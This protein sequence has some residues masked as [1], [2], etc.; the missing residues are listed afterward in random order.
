MTQDVM[1][2]DKDSGYVST[3]DKAMTEFEF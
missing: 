2:H 3:N 1:S